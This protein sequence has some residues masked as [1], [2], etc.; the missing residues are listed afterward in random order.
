MD[1]SRLHTVLSPVNYYE[2]HEQ[3]MSV[4]T[5]G[6]LMKNIHDL[7]AHQLTN[8]ELIHKS[9]YLL[10]GL[11][12]KGT[13]LNVES[14]KRSINGYIHRMSSA[15]EFN[16]VSDDLAHLLLN[17]QRSQDNAKLIVTGNFKILN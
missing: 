6:Q 13:R 14:L 2:T 1:L 7:L 10:S 8:L 17:F 9:P 4:R 5:Y 15:G 16:Y 3:R 12:K 11:L